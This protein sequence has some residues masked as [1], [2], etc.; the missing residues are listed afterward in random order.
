MYRNSAKKLLSFG[1]TDISNGIC[2]STI[3]F[4]RWKVNLSMGDK[5][6][7]KQRDEG[8]YKN[9]KQTEGSGIWFGRCKTFKG[10]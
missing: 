7:R 8:N 9:G 10:L 3:M 2:S 6:E 4:R 5:N 1:E